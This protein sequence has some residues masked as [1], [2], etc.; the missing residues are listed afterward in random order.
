MK[1]KEKSINEIRAK[2]NPLKNVPLLDLCEF[3]RCHP[4]IGEL[5]HTWWISWHR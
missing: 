5:E 4:A 3:L 1:L 2:K